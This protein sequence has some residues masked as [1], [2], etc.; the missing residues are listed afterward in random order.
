MDDNELI[1][2]CT[3]QNAIARLSALE[4]LR[5]DIK[6]SGSKW[7]HNATATELLSSIAWTLCDSNPKIAVESFHFLLDFIPTNLRG[8]ESVLEYAVIPVLINSLGDIKLQ[9]RRLALQVLKVYLE[10][11]SSVEN[12]LEALAHYGLESEDWRVRKEAAAAIPMLIPTNIPGLNWQPLIGALVNRLRDISD[13]VIKGAILVLRHIGLTIGDVVLMNVINRLPGLSRQLFRQ[14]QEKILVHGEAGTTNRI[15]G[16][17]TG[18]RG[19]P[20]RPKCLSP[21]EPAR[22]PSRNSQFQETALLPS[23]PHSAKTRVVPM[24]PQ[25]AD[26]DVAFGLIPVV[27]V[28]GLHSEVDWRRRSMAIENLHR[29]VIAADDVVPLLP[30][31]DQFVDFLAPFLGDANFKIV[32]T[33]LRILSDLTTRVGSA[34][35]PNLEKTVHCLIQ[36]LGD[37]KVAIRQAAAKLVLQL[38]HVTA[39]ELVLTIVLR[40][41][42]HDSPKVREEIVN[43]VTTALLTFPEA[44]WDFP[45]IIKE[46][47]GTLKDGKAK[48]KYVTVEAYSVVAAT[49][50]PNRMQEILRGFGLDEETLHLLDLRFMDRTLPTLNSE[51]SLEHIISR[52]TVTTPQ[53]MASPTKEHPTSPTG[54]ALTRVNSKSAPSLAGRPL[55]AQ[56]TGNFEEAL[57]GHLR[58]LD[59]ALS[60]TTESPKEG[61]KSRGQTAR[62]IKLPW[63]R[64]RSGTKYRYSFHGDMHRSQN[65]ASQDGH[66]VRSFSDSERILGHG[67]TA[68]SQT[69]GHLPSGDDIKNDYHIS[70]GS[71]ASFDDAATQ[72]KSQ[73]SLRMNSYPSKT[74]PSSHRQSTLAGLRRARPKLTTHWNQSEDDFR[75]DGKEYPLGDHPQSQSAPWLLS[76]VSSRDSSA[77]DITLLTTHPTTMSP[78]PFSSAPTPDLDSQ[79]D[80]Q[81]RDMTKPTAIHRNTSNTGNRASITTFGTAEGASPAAECSEPNGKSPDNSIACKRSATVENSN[82]L[83]PFRNRSSEAPSKTQTDGQVEDGSRTFAHDSSQ[84]AASSPQKKFHAAAMTREEPPASAPPGLQRTK[85]SKNFEQ[86]Y[87]LALQQLRNNPDWTVKVESVEKLRIILA[88]YP[89]LFNGNLHE[90]LLAV[91]ATVHNLRSSVSKHA[92]AFLHDMYMHLGKA[93]EAD[94][95]MTVGSLLKKVGEGNGFIV[96]EADRALSA[97]CD[98][99]N[100]SRSVGSL[101]LFAD[102]KNP[103]IRMRVASLMG[104][105]VTGTSEAQAARY[106]QSYGD[107]GKLLTA[108]VQFLRDGLAETRNA[109]KRMLLF[110]SQ[111]PDFNKV[112]E[113]VLAIKQVN[114]VHEALKSAT[115]RESTV[116]TRSAV[117]GALVRAPSKRNVKKPR[118]KSDV[119]DMDRLN[120]IYRDMIADDWRKRYQGIMDVIGFVKEYPSEMMDRQRIQM[121]FDHYLERCR[122]GNSKVGLLGL[123]SLQELIPALKT[124]LDPVI[125]TLVQTLAN[126]MATASAVIR[127]A[128]VQAMD[129][130]I[131]NGDNGLILQSL[132]NIVQFG[133]NARVKP[134]LLE[135]MIP[136]ID[137]VYASKPSVVIKYAVPITMRFLQ[138]AKGDIRST[139]AK[140]LKGLFS[141]M[142]QSLF[143][144]VGHMTPEVHGKL[145]ATLGC[146]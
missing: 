38:M 119:R 114:E 133:S 66:R 28:Q 60:A 55:L 16:V 88:E 39:P 27:I 6:T 49:L 47:L 106:I 5:A 131:A 43:I 101:L 29:C 54:K 113:K 84:R 129:T 30:F 36:I 12:M 97:M 130:L 17:D 53:P 26:T 13:V 117:T 69:A 31:L 89:P 98:T 79:W 137:N 65:E 37:A 41:A 64:P 19:S 8:C 71:P 82:G 73:A 68:G 111:L 122:D 107:A 57:Q 109:A 63:E 93:M 80:G 76:D 42:R 127:T 14:Y 92:I 32:M 124:G 125:H 58:A 74:Q 48:V 145:M 15:G 120:I 103:A 77:A 11:T 90:L 123:Q 4:T 52:S 102:H 86:D 33:T 118:E 146:P 44:Q 95:D 23:P 143:E 1:L 115:G 94:L 2:A 40:Y 62:T 51:G 136:V 100:P 108:L 126:Q 10:H 144:H 75:T 59:R 96:E 45:C 135:Q 105:V 91:V 140:L 67:P 24:E 18:P 104:R 110:L 121:L 81:P 142:G 9:H 20:E 61:T 87:R 112:T 78:L 22:T 132:A 50:S 7:A 128:T 139:N 3:S 85:T 25:L 72:G 141:L 21:R 83:N 138:E 99:V 46:L 116:S 35:R 70:E 134:M 56:R 34:V